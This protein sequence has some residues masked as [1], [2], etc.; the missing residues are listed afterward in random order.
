MSELPR[1]TGRF[2]LETYEQLRAIAAAHFAREF[3]GHTLQPTA[4]VHEA[5]LRLAGQKG[6]WQ[7]QAHF[8][9]MASTM[10]RRV[11]VDHARSKS[12]EKRGGE[13]ARVS[14][15]AAMP[16]ATTRTEVDVLALD[17][18]MN[19]LEGLN[20]RHARVVELRYFGGLTIEQT[21][22]A[23]GVSTTTVENDW[24]LARAWL[25]REMEGGAA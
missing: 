18:A 15:E 4:V 10:I 20:A 21:S 16:A 24:A 17:D 6:G 8:C 23:L 13:A 11:L 7:D 14:L 2:A 5:Y 9:A 19:R 22:R 1:E 3:P 25:R 12:A